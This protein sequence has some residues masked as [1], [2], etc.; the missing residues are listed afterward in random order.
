MPD[1]VAVADG[2]ATV[3]TAVGVAT[4]E[5]G[6]GVGVTV[7]AWNLPRSQRRYPA[8]SKIT[9]I[10][11]K[12]VTFRLNLFTSLAG[13][14]FDPIVHNVFFNYKVS[15]LYDMMQKTHEKDSCFSIP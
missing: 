5:T 15:N 8:I 10:I 1:G 4:S 3:G 12:I 14:K 7:V 6:V 11:T 2:L 9:K 13:S